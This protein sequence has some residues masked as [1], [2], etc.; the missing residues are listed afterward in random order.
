MSSRYF[1]IEKTI[2]SIS[3]GRYEAKKP[4]DAAKKIARKLLTYTN[5]PKISFSIRETTKNSQKKIYHYEATKTEVHATKVFY[6]DNKLV[7]ILHRLSDANYADR[8]LII[9]SAKEF[10]A[11]KGYLESRTRLNLKMKIDHIMVNEG[12][13]IFDTFLHNRIMHIEI[14]KE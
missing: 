3:K 5:D 14:A 8:Q 6:Y 2:V 11:L 1:T 10:T 7:E 4:I 12:S 13:I 9:M